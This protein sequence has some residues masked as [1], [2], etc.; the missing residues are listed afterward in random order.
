MS[1]LLPFLLVFIIALAIGV[2]IGKLLF[3]AQSQSEK[4]FLE[5]KLNNLKE[6][7]QVEKTT[8]ERQLQ[9]IIQ[10]SRQKR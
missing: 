9:Q 10:N 5:E 2:F 6:Q 7:S 8:L 1:T 3:S 4:A